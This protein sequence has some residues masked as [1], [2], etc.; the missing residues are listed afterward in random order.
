MESNQGTLKDKILSEE[1]IYKAIYSMESYVF[2]KG[3]LSE[4]DLRTYVRLQDKFDFEYIDRFIMV[5]QRRLTH[6]LDNPSLLFP[7]KVYFKIKKWEDGKVKFRPIHTAC[8]C[9]QICMVCMLM[10]LMFEDSECERKKSELTKLIP[11]NFYGNIPSTNVRELFEPWK[12]KYKDYTHAII[13]HCKE[14]KHN[15]RYRTELTLDIKDFFPSIHPKFIYYYVYQLMESLYPKKE[16]KKVLETVLA[17]L[18]YFVVDERNLKDWT[19][20]YYGDKVPELV[21]G[22]FVNRGIAQGLPQSYLFGNLCTIEIEKQLKRNGYLN[23][24]DSYY[25]VDDSVIY[26]K[27][28]LKEEGFKN[29]ITQINTA[30]RKISAP[31]D[32]KISEDVI[33]AAY[34]N[35]C[36]GLGYQ[37]QYHD[38]KKSSYCAI[39]DAGYDIEGLELLKEEISNAGSVFDNSDEVEDYFCRDKLMKLTEIVNNEISRITP[40][41]ESEDY[42]TATQLKWLKRYNRYF[43]YRLRCLDFKQEE[44]LGTNKIIDFCKNF[45]LEPEDWNT[46][47]YEKWFDNFDKDIFQN[48]GRLLLTNLPM[49]EAESFLKE[50]LKPFESKLVNSTLAGNEEANAYLL[51]QKDFTATLALR[52]LQAEPYRSLGRWVRSCYRNKLTQSQSLVMK[53]LCQIYDNLSED[54]ISDKSLQQICPDYV[55][56]ILRTSPDFKRKILNAYFSGVIGVQPSDS[57]AFVKFVG[58]HLCYTELRVLAWLRNPRFVWDDFGIFIQS[59]NAKALENGMPIDMSVLEVLDSFIKYVKEPKWVDTLIQTHRVVKGLWYNGSKF[60][61]SYTLHNEEHAVTLIHKS[62]RLLKAIDYLAIKQIDYYILY[63]ACYLHDISMVIH[64]NIRNFCNGDERSMQ[65][66]SEFISKLQKIHQEGVLLT[67]A[68]GKNIPNKKLGNFLID[69]FE[70]IFD[71]FTDEVRNTHA[72][73][74]AKKI[75]EWHDG[76]LKFINQAVLSNVAEVAESHG[77]E[78]EEVYGMKS[79]AKD[80]LISTKYMMMLIRLADLMDVA[81]DRVNYYL[82]QQNVEH[83]NKDSRFHW[84]SHL[85]TD[86]IQVDPRFYYDPQNDERLFERPLH[87][88]LNFNLFLN[89][90]Y[91]SSMKANKECKQCL[92]KPK[93]DSEIVN[94]PDEMSDAEGFM[95]EVCNPG[96][97]KTESC[98]ILCNW[99]MYKH[100]W[101]VNELEQLQRYLNQVNSLLIR[102]EIRLNV[103]YR[104]EY[105]LESN[106]FDCVKQYLE[107][108]C[109]EEEE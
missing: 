3:L 102:T 2:E 47:D 18:L 31:E 40:C 12:R 100:R 80:S 34:T 78:V 38:D 92:M 67:N 1:N 15:H 93:L 81:Q 30:M 88:R 42:K 6:M 69:E 36:D 8:L 96:H 52:K 5:V 48:E 13:T 44:D 90:K 10:P 79:L 53:G 29:L 99:I 14:Y 37:I 101:L 91:M 104:N 43:L 7:I 65:I 83:L 109:E 9:D 62:N 22:K 86:M 97:K 60:M 20:Q 27:E 108:K 50:K 74:S 84:I 11:H 82:L 45:H 71:Y 85:T 46:F 76:I 105:Q 94:L 17:K 59:M 55:R 28:D 54:T 58:R 95:I 57:K 19:S 32:V 77:A 72:K 56:F 75:R 35:E 70:K 68:D 63:L 61:N 87:E 26:I 89:V 51:L 16:D 107:E 73:E 106:L 24:C 4:K 103:I 66:I 64:P 39:E 49:D 33:D 41:N 98:P 25:Y 23:D 21:N